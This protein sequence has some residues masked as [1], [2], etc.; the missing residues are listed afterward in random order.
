MKLLKAYQRMD[1]EALAAL[2]VRPDVEAEVEAAMRAFLAYTLDRVA[3]IPGVPR[4]GAGGG[5]RRAA[6]HADAVA[7]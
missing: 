5:T 2:R 1:V 6:G 3:A 4:R 7:G